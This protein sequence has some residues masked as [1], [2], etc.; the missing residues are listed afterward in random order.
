[1]TKSHVPLTSPQ[2]AQADDAIIASD[3][4]GFGPSRPQMRVDVKYEDA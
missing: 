3:N 2:T 4:V 1:M